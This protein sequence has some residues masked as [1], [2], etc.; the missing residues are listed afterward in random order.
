M[1]SSHDTNDRQA[2]ATQPNVGATPIKTVSSRKSSK[3]IQ[4]DIPDPLKQGG[5]RAGGP[6]IPVDA[7]GSIF[8]LDMALMQI[9]KHS[10]QAA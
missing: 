7:E 6:E 2:L 4:I 9:K 5:P 1:E 10:E 8:G 3:M